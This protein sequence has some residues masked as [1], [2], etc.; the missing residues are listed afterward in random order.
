MTDSRRLPKLPVAPE[1]GWVTL[2][3]VAAMGYI[4]AAAIDDAGWV[5]GKSNLT[6]FLV[7]AVLLGVLAG[8][9]G[10]KVGWNRWVANLVG[11]LFAALIVPI[12]VGDVLLPPGASI[13]SQ[14]VA[15]A[16][17][18]KGA[19]IDLVINKAQLTRET[20]HHLLI[21]GLLCWGTGQFAASAVFRHHRPLSAVVVI[22]AFLVGN[23]VATTQ[24]Q[25]GYLILFSIVA[26]FL[27]TRLH[28]LDEEATWARRRIGDPSDVGRLYSRGG[29]VFI[30]VAIL[31][32]LVLTAS[33]H[34]APLAG[35]W[36]DLKP[37][38]LD[39]SAAIERFLPTLENSRG[40]G[41]VQFGST[42]TIRGTW[43]TPGGLA[44]TVQRTPGDDFPY[45]WRAV[46]YDEFDN[47][48]WRWNASEQVTLPRA[49]GEELLAGTLDQVTKPGTKDITFNVVPDELRGTFAMSPLAPVS[50]DRDSTLAG[51]SEFGLFEAI[52]ISGNAPYSITARV[53]LIGDEKGGL[54]QN[55]L[56]AAGTG[57]PIELY[58]RY[59]KLPPGAV[60]P[61]A[62]KVLNDVLQ[63]MSALGVEDN[64][65]NLAN[66]LKTALQSSPFEYSANV[67]DQ[68]CGQMSASECFAKYK[69]GYCEHY[70]TLMTVLLREHKIPARFVEGFLPGDIDPRTG[71][72]PVMNAN[73]HAWVEVYFP[74]YGWYM[75]DPT[76]NNQDRTVAL[77]TGKTV[78][79]APPSRFPSL[80][81]NNERDQEGPSRNPNAVPPTGR[82][83][84]VGPGGYILITLVLLA[85][86][87]IMAFLVWRRGPRGP[88][89]PEGAWL[90]IGR[91]AARFGFGPRPT[92]TA[93]EYAT[94]LG[95]VLPGIRPELQTVATAK[96][97]VAY[98]GR[99][100]D[101]D[102]L[103]AIRDSYKKLRVGLLRLLFRRRDR[104]SLRDRG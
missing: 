11:A 29:A 6:D 51:L 88:V 31:G 98:G 76:G 17:A 63:R 44:M 4:L 103:R 33:A 54:T 79:S 37:W 3:L 22:G 46:A 102:R 36:N 75:F 21:L 12:L 92:Q 56:A 15:T 59:T 47:F 83:G 24:P 14:F 89:T 65:W 64:A 5:L 28:A 16:D 57:Y 30:S 72:E 40:I 48:G 80:L 86:V 91:L 45:Y 81:P 41:A 39:V 32:S 13:G 7:I 73:A 23:M 68:D 27:L 26:L 104:R 8:F 101:D 9:I 1:E 35:A 25:L 96:V 60:G 84:G 43:T 94:A 61:E 100:L 38:L 90:G 78:A 10:A 69:R 50:I 49:A 2:L 71:V 19:W 70:A 42:A 66:A 34:S 95:E 62:E 93:Y 52:Q 58:T 53:P 97:E 67:L 82:D 87:S 20:G 74:G 18:A 99:V 77:P 85:T 55:K